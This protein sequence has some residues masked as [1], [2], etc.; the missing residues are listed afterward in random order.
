MACEIAIRALRPDV[1]EY[2]VYDYMRI[3]PAVYSIDGLKAEHIPTLLAGRDSHRNLQTIAGP[4]YLNLLKDLAEGHCVTAQTAYALERYIRTDSDLDI[5]PVRFRPG[6]KR[7]G[8]RDA[9][10]AEQVS[11]R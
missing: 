6:K 10:S 7:L 5:G 3:I 9:S 1:S 8:C 11:L 2:W 4:D